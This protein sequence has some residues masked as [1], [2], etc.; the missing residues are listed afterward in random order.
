MFPALDEQVVWRGNVQEVH[1]GQLGLVGWEQFGHF[2]IEVQVFVDLCIKPI[3]IN[4]CN[5]DRSFAEVIFETKK[6]LLGL[7]IDMNY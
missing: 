5:S 7:K 1:F 6:N 2:G 3:I 4:V